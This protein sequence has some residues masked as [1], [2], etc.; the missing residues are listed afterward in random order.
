MTIK[1]IIMLSFKYLIPIYFLLLIVACGGEQVNS[2]EPSSE[3]ML[4]ANPP[5]KGFNIADSDEKAIALADSVMEAMGGRKHW[6]ETRFIHWNFFGGRRL[7]WDKEKKRAR[8]ESLRDN[9]IYLVDIKTGNSK[10]MMNG[11]EMTDQDSLAKY[12][13]RGMNMWINDSYWLVLPF[14]LKDSGVTLK[15]LGQDSTDAGELTEVLQLTFK[16][17]GNTPQNKYLVY[18][19]PES[20]MITQWDYY[21]N[22]SDAEPRFS[23]PWADYKQHGKIL[24]SGNRGQRE[25]SEIGVYREVPD[26]AFESFESVDLDD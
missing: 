15:H 26:A 25:I 1:R 8:V 22:A 10:V 12:G 14:K 3:E 9:S 23:T 16:E 13:V 17:V 7:L 18:I 5:A 20:Y 24:L 11:E 19:N 6:D 21:P 2:E 4:D